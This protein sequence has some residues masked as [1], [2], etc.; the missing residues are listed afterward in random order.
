MD[1]NWAFFFIFIGGYATGRISGW[2]MHRK[3][4]N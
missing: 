2:L 4:N 3:D 1:F